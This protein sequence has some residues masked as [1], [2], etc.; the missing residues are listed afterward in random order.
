MIET[1]ERAVMRSVCAP[2]CFD[3][4]RATYRSQA[5]APHMHE[6][7]AI[8]VIESG[9]NLLRYRGVTHTVRMGGVVVVEPG[10]VHTGRPANESGWTYRM[11]YLPTAM[12]SRLVVESSMR[13]EAPAFAEPVYYDSDLASRLVAAHRALELEADPLRSEVML[14][15]SLAHLMRR[16][17]GAV[18]REPRSAPDAVRRVREYLEA[19]YARPVTLAELSDIARLSRYH[20]IR[21]FRRSVGLPPYMYLEQVRIER[22]KQLLRAGASISHVAYD[23]GFSDQSHLTRL[24]KRLVGVPPGHYARGQRGT[25][26]GEPVASGG[27]L[28]A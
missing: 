26:L 4:L 10:E 25:A 15:E 17:G 27:R 23:T 11:L 28:V 7:Y 2:E 24:F 22:A 3:L 14:A 6:T 13:P 16:H 12:I 18:H 20:L 21:I 19:H 9:A 8:G 5:F 1:Q